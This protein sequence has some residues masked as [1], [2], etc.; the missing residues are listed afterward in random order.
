VHE[1]FRDFL[2][3]FLTHQVRFL[4]VG[5]H[6]LAVHGVPRATGDLDVWV[7]PTRANADRVWQALA[8]FGAPLDALRISWDDFTRPDVVVQLGLPPRRIDLL[9]AVSGLSFAE[10][11]EDRLEDTVDDLRLPFLGRESLIRNKRAS[12]RAKDLGDLDALG[13]H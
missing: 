11:W 8:A 2:A 6:A 7:E 3:A 4:V 9:T 13:E 1:D 12:G 10:A 5:A